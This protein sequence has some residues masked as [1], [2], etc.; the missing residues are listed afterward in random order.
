VAVIPR[1]GGDFVWA[2]RILHPTAGL[3]GNLLITFTLVTTNGVV[4]AWIVIYGLVPMFDG[5]GIVTSNSSLTNLAVKI[6]TLPNSFIISLVVLCIFIT[7]LFLSTKN[8]F[9]YLTVV[10]GIALIS[11]LVL[12]GAF[13]SAPNATF[14]ANFNRLSGMNYAS[15]IS[16]AGLPSG[17]ILSATLTGGVFTIINFLGFNNSAYYGGEIKNAE[18]SQLFGMFGASLIGA[19]IM[20]LLY[21]S[22]Y[23][24]VGPNFLNAISFL[25]GSGSSSYTLPA[26]PT[27]NFLAVFASPNPFVVVATS[28]ALIATSVGSL[29]AFTF[30][31][32][33][34]MFAWSFDRILPSWLTK[35]DSKRGSPYVSVIVLWI[36][37]ILTV[38]G[39][40]YT[41]FFQFY[42]Y[43]ALAYFIG[44]GIVSV[45]AII[46]PY[47]K[48]EMFESSPAV[49]KKRL[50]G[51]PVITILG[52]AGLISSIFISY[53]S[54]SPAVTPPPSGALIRDLAYAIVPLTI[55]SALIIYAV[56]YYYR[57]SK[58]MNLDLVFKEIPPE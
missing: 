38:V 44:Y 33:R 47:R 32:V 43:S 54:L 41:A 31:C 14:V 56:S 7:P 3:V 40:Y 9:R 19:G 39:Y 27:L 6:S 10:F 34:N 45:A 37:S 26:A 23:Y 16:T 52:V 35:V 11:T 4:A 12:I 36:I 20:G 28:I 13:L 49:V 18:R 5:L 24:S 55:I 25:A 46:F 21:A 50:G 53:S 30:V 42:I 22:A 29:T 1:T 48:K 58:G 8:V 2:S 17:F 51:I 15:A 57:R